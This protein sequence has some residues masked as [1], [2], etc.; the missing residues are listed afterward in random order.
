[1]A[2]A[3]TELCVNCCACEPLCPNKAIQEAQPHFRIDAATCSECAGDYDDPQCAQICPI[4]CAIIDERGMP[5]NALGSLTGIRDL[6]ATARGAVDSS[7]MT[8]QRRPETLS[9]QAP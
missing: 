5:L 3:I 1:M 2:L 7:M 8:R 4:E 9:P 6:K